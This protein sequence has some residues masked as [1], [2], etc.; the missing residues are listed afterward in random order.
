MLYYKFILINIVS[1]ILEFFLDRTRVHPFYI[2]GSATLKESDDKHYN[3]NDDDHN[4]E[5]TRNVIF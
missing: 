3:D 5:G 4:K 1:L 2:T